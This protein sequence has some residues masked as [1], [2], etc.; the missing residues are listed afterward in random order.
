MVENITAAPQGALD[1]YRTQFAAISGTVE[2]RISPPARHLNLRA[3]AAGIAAFSA[4]LGVDMPGASRWAHGAGGATVVWLGPNEWLVI[5]P[6]DTS[7]ELEQQLREAAAGASIA[8]TDQSGQRLSVVVSGDAAGLLSKG[9]AID[10]HPAVFVPG[11]AIQSFVGQAVVVLLARSDNEIELL[12]RTSF[13]R[14][15]GDWLVD[16]LVDPLAYPAV[17]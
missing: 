5:A 15:V 2:V 14:Y 1:T 10:V 7:H 9:T 8:V 3:D 4:V 17:L 12:V 11:T 13:A 6:L 16:A